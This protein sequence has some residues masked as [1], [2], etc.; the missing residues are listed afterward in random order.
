MALT[1]KRKML[2]RNIRVRAA[3]IEW[4]KSEKLGS[5]ALWETLKRI[6]EERQVGQ[7]KKEGKI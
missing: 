4:L 1:E 6:R 2:F 7:L 5:E 3:E